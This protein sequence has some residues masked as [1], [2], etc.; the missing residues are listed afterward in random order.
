MTTALFRRVDEPPHLVEA[1]TLEHTYAEV[2]RGCS[3]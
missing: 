1:H 3:R 2:M